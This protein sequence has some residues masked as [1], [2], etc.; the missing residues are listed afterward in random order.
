MKKYCKLFILAAALMG[1]LSLNSCIDLDPIDY[2]DINPS[3][4]PQTETDVESI[5][6]SC[7]YS[8][9]SSWFDGLFSTSER[10]VTVVNDL[11]TEILTC[12]SGFLKDVSDLNFSQPPPTLPASTTQIQMHT[13]TV[14]SMT[15]AAAPPYWHRLKHATS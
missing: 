5:V 12:K 11:T 8:V 2:S 13:A 10:G 3:N 14:G 6:N 4:F 15:S 1:G 7:Y 9:R